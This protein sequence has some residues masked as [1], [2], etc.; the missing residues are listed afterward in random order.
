M[1]VCA[2]CDTDCVPTR[3]HVI[4]D[5]YGSGLGKDGW[6][7]FNAKR[8][9]IHLNGQLQI[10]DVCE[11]CNNVR[12]GMLDAYA[13]SIYENFLNVPAYYGETRDFEIDRSL[14]LRWLLKVCYNSARVHNADV[15]I[16]RKYRRYI[17]GQ[18]LEPEPV[19]YSH[20][21]TATDF[22]TDPPTAAKRIIEG[23]PHIRPPR[24]FRITQ[25]RGDTDFVTDIVQR[26]VYIDSY[27]FTVFAVDP[28][29][30][31]HLAELA[32]VESKFKQTFP[33]SK[34]IPTDGKLPLVA[35]D[36]HA[37]EMM[38]PHILNYPSRY[39]DGPLSS[40][41]EFAGM[42]GELVNAKTKIVGLTFTQEEVN[43]GDISGLVDRLQELVATRES[44]MA[45]KQRL[46]MFTTDYDNDS[47][48]LWDIPEV[49]I[50]LHR[51]FLACP[52]IFFL[53]VHGS[54]TIDLFMCCCCKQVNRTDD[55]LIEFD[56]DDLQRFLQF[57][58]VGMNKVTQRLAISVEISNAITDDVL[59]VLTG[60]GKAIDKAEIIGR[61]S[62]A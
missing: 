59:S 46:I 35:R 15:T 17:I 22:S 60:Q 55:G 42:I 50:F 21:V 27:C 20:L 34:P 11:Q 28:E 14:F 32:R 4:P 30:N 53:A 51:L 5:W 54:L 36:I 33:L 25:F 47:R 23:D 9:T 37:A 48:E 56:P 62:R 61:L 1:S 26:Q 18:N 13:K 16:L 10:K 38:M 12:L 31:R 3:E 2:Y 39:G 8:P 49:R 43:A 44:A 7:L 58:F 24:W 45:S 57:G 40:S 41:S 52:F 6:E 19:V 29:V